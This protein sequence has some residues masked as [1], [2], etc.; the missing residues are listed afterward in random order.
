[1]E[2]LRPLSIW[3][4]SVCGIGMFFMGVGVSYVSMGIMDCG[5]KLFIIGLLLEVPAFYLVFKHK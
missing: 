4:W 1:M 3:E 2:K 5:I